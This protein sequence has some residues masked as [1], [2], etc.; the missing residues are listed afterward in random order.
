MTKEE[1]SQLYHLNK[2]LEEQRR[3][4]AQLESLVTSG[5]GRITGMPHSGKTSDMVATCA[6]EIADLSE[7][8][9]INTRRCF[10]ELNRLSNFINNVTDSEM[11]R[12]LSFRY[13]S[14]LSWNQVVIS[15]GGNKSPN[16]LR[17]AVERFLE[18]S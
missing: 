15:M 14:G 3:R 13:I 18:S 4:S 17:M 12:M 2:E 16:T 1:M 11:R 10:Q 7:C 6:V 8:I 9:D 5:T